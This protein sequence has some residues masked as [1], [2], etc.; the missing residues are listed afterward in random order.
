LIGAYNYEMT[1]LP[2]EGTV[3]C[4]CCTKEVPEK[5]AM[6]GLPGTK[7]EGW[8]LCLDCFNEYGDE[9]PDTTEDTDG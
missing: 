6:D 1:D 3:L 7:W 4:D 9:P 5:Y 8:L 2:D